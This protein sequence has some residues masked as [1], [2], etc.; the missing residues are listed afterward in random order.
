MQAPPIPEDEDERIAVLTCYDILDTLPEAV[1]DDLVSLAAHV[2]GTPIALVSLVD[3]DR[4]WFKARLGLDATE[5]PR[6]VSFCGHVVAQREPLV[7]NDAKQDERFSDNPLVEGYPHVEFYAGMPLTTP[8]G[9]T[10]GTLCVIDHQPRELS[11]QQLELLEA[12]GRQVTSQLELRLRTRLDR[13]RQLQL[14][15]LGAEAQ[16]ANRAKSSFLANMSHELRTP[17]NSILGFSNLL[18]KNK[19]G[20]LD[21][22]ELEYLSRVQKNGEH[23][24]RLV[25]EVLDLSKV[26]AGQMEAN[27]QPTDLFEVVDDV[28]AQVRGTAELKGTTLLRR[29]PPGLKRVEVDAHLLAQILLNL[30][31]NALRFAEGGT[32]CVEVF[33]EGGCARRVQVSDDGPGVPVE[34]QEAIFDAFAQA[35]NSTARRYGGTGLGLSISRKLGELMGLEL[36]VVSTPGEGAT[37]WVAFPDGSPPAEHVTPT[38]PEAKGSP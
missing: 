28:V 19:R 37:F 3:T 12:L 10:L 1:Y 7:V 30:L 2:A 11:D 20:N 9:Y 25:G 27:M 17:L 8:E 13:E 21:E 33:A 31:G 32:V 5:T 22:R 36:G 15:R 23:L 24:L 4:Q 35:E 14:E 34:R 38:R 26:E 6:S 29:I 16:R 18:A